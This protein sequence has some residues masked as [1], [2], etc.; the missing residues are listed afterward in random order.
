VDNIEDQERSMECQQYTTT[1]RSQIDRRWIERYRE[2]V[3]YDSYWWLTWAG[4]FTEEERQ[5]WSRLSVLSLDEAIKVQ[6]SALMKQSRERELAAA[7][8]EQREPRLH[9][10]AIVI[11]DVRSRIAAHLQL[12]AEIDRDEPH[13][14]VRRLYQ[15]VIEGE[16]DYLHLIE[17]TY[18]RNTEQ[19]R[20]SSLRLFLLPTHEEMEYA[21][22]HIQRT[23]AQGLKKPETVSISQHLQ[24]FLQI[25]LHL[26]LS[27]EMEGEKPLEQLQKTPITQPQEGR[28]ISV[29]TAQRFFE[30]ILKESG[31][32]GWK[33]II[34][35]N[36]NGARVEK[37]SRCLFLPE[38]DISLA[39]VKRLLAHEL[40][41]HVARCVAGERSPLG[42]L[43]IGTKNVS[44][45]EEGF[46]LYHERQ[47]AAVQG[48]T[49]DDSGM[50]L[51]IFA[52]GL[53]SGIMGPP[54]TF[55]SICSFVE[56]FSLLRRL[57]K[58]PE[59]G[60]EQHQK[61][62]R[63]YALDHCLRVFRGVPD[64]NQA[65][66]CYS[67][68]AIYLHGLFMIEKAVAQDATV[69][70]CFAVGKV[71]LDLLPDMQELGITTS[72]LPS[73]YPRAYE[74]GLDAYILSFE[75]VKHT[76]EEG[77]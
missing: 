29:H 60:K 43:G 27:L 24:D 55:Y 67:Q 56:L 44:C 45:T 13:P 58:H 15:G 40:A 33:V 46:V 70:D 66:V 31:Y 5:A 32:E 30:A 25:H 9:Y 4:P 20:E 6:L 3:S 76:L 54:Q 63:A 35:A 72:A 64:L 65:G 41:G 28:T 21:L 34:D 37:G 19:F 51:S 69:L 14:I 48:Q 61:Q 57:L 26:S 8:A 74:P 36:A 39:T 17:A 18:E 50:R 71:A 68:D 22:T 38:E 1:P 53:A 11:E 12:K 77:P 52:I 59:K 23:L 62:A 73:L 10:P 2:L 16:L 75:E 49:W 42:L 47:I 7:M